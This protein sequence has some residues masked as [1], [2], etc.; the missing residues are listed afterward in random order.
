MVARTFCHFQIGTSIVFS[1][2]S[3]KKMN[4]TSQA[5]AWSLL[6]I[7]DSSELPRSY[8]TMTTKRLLLRGRQGAVL[9]EDQNMLLAEFDQMLYHTL[10]D[11]D[12]RGY[13]HQ[14]PKGR[15]LLVKI[16]TFPTSLTPR[17]FNLFLPR[18]SACHY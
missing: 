2:T 11:L 1:T 18:L 13:E 9:T 15:I 8:S 3:Q 7:R 6:K 10:L 16:L 14:V 17:I 12:Q 4:R 5:Y